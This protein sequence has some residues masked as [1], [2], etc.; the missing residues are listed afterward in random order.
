ME[1]G[2]TYEIAA[3]IK[4]KNKMHDAGRINIKRSD[5]RG[6]NYTWVGSETVN[7]EEWTLVGGLYELQISGALN[8]LELYT[9]G[10]GTGVEY[11]VDNVVVREVSA[12]PAA[13]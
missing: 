5:D 10:P 12:T 11:Y 13:E 8:V 1:P 3:W 2:R 7:D 6:D 9:E 4:L